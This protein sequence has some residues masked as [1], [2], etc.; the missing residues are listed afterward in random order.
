MYKH[1]VA[2]EDG[3]GST[4]LLGFGYLGDARGKEVVKTISEKYLGIIDSTLVNDKCVIV[5]TLPLIGKV[6][7]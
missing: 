6:V 3:L 5:D 1:I 2:F 7:Q 4:M